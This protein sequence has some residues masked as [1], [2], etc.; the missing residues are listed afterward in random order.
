ML[1]KEGE[2]LIPDVWI[3]MERMRRAQLLRERQLDQ[4]AALLPTR[5][6]LRLRLARGLHALAALLEGL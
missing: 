4:L 1:N 6:G 3:E 2:M 5:S